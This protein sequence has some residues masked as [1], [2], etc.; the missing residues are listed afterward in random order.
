MHQ[1]FLI[2]ALERL[3]DLD[4]PDEVCPVA[5]PAE[6]G[7]LACLDSDHLWEIDLD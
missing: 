4:L 2:A 1:R 6:A 7:H 3:L 5:L